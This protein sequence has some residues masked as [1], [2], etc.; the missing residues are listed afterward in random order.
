M[1]TGKV[2]FFDPDKGFG[3]ISGPDGQQVYVHASILAEDQE[4]VQGTKVE[5]SMVDGRKGPQALSVRVLEDAKPLRK[6]RKSPDEMAIIVEDLVKLLDDVGNKFKQGQ[7]PERG[8][9]KKVAQMLRH[10]AG[11]FDA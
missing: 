5:Y 1:P 4:L 10:V 2:R 8:R 3:F 11:E 9:S 6:N 7:M